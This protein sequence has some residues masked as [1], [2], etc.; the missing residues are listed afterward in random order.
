MSDNS[1]QR[2]AELMFNVVR[3]RYG[4][5]LDDEQLEEVRKGVE[6]IFEAAESLREIKLENADEPFSLFVPYRKGD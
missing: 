5:R 6:G 1:S 2:E 3:E 4:D